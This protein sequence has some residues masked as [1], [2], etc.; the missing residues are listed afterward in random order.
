M[1]GMR[2]L[3]ALKE[4]GISYE[5][6]EE[7]LAG[8]KSQLLL[9]SNPIHKKVPVLIHNGKP[10]C[11]SLLI[12]QYIDEAWPSEVSCL[13][14]KD[15]FQRATARFWADFVD[16]KFANAAIRIVTSPE[17]EPQEQAKKEFIEYFMLLESAL[18]EVADG[19]PY[20]G[21]DKIGLMD[22]AFA[23]FISWFEAYENIG[24]FKIPDEHQCPLLTAW[25]QRILEYPS[26][27]EA[28]PPFAKVAE[29]VPKFRRMALGTST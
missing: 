3:I 11:E 4:K 28:L 14:P 8:S 12:V 19:K 10:I 2:V 29:V 6:E 23:P 7:D 21:G 1:Y 22:I 18:R 24:G 9:S 27:K 15:P 16:K 5:Y 26:V 20:F 25:I 13:V 17:G